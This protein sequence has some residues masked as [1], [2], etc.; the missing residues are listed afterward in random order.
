MPNPLTRSAKGVQSLWHGLVVTQVRCG[1]G[2]GHHN[3]FDCDLLCVGLRGK[4]RLSNKH[5]WVDAEPA[6]RLIAFTSP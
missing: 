1:H 5:I 2:M 6:E 4:T 3:R